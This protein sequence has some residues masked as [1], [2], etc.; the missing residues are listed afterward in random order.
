MQQGLLAPHGI[1]L[2]FLLCSAG[3]SVA[4]CTCTCHNTAGLL[5]FPLPEHAL[6]N[7]SYVQHW[8]FLCLKPEACEPV[9]GTSTS[10]ELAAPSEASKQATAPTQPIDL[11]ADELLT[12]TRR[13]LDLLQPHETVLPALRR[14]GGR[15]EGMQGGGEAMPWK[16]ARKV[17][18]RSHMSA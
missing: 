4:C 1:V 10:S 17:A 6:V 7:L 18:G 9:G 5:A 15:M 2:S 11:D 3:V 14:L 12:Y 8:D 16:R 13:L